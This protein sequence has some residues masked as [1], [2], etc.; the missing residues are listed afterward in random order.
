MKPHPNEKSFIEL[1]GKLVAV[2][3]SAEAGLYTAL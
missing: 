1:D 3:Y 2:T